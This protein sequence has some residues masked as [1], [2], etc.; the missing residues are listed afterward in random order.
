MLSF[1][2]QRMLPQAVRKMIHKSM[3]WPPWGL[4]R[5]GNL[6][7]LDPISRNWGFDRGL[8][9]DRYYIEKFL[10]ANASDIQGHV[11]EFKEDLYSSRFG[12]DRVRK[13]DVLHIVE[14]NPAAT[15]VADL[16]CANQIQS[17]TF[18]CI[19]CTQTIHFIYEVAAAIKTLYRV[20]KPGGVLLATVPGISQV[21]R[22]DM[23]HWGD[24]WR[25]TTLSARLLFEE[26]FQKSAIAVNAWGNVITAISFLHGL[27]SEELKKKELDYVDQDYELLI[28][29]R[30]VKPEI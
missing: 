1:I 23:D 21:S 9:M 20:L 27:A 6:R 10:S 30:A 4:V 2:K 22:Y 24:Y 17:D 14:G 18:D 25:F 5:F 12:G 3:L 7:D 19:I 16:S 26:V 28:A 29:I 15:I 8:P 13:I 11:L